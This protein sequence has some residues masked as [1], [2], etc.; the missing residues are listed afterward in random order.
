MKRFG[1]LFFVLLFAL[2]CVKDPPKVPVKG[3]GDINLPTSD[4]LWDRLKVLTKEPDAAKNGVCNAIAYLNDKQGRKLL[5]DCLEPII[6]EPKENVELRRNAIDL[7]IL[8]N[9]TDSIPSLKN[10]TSDTRAEIRSKAGEALLR[11]ADPSGAEALLSYKGGYNSDH[12]G[13]YWLIQH[14]DI[15]PKD[16]AINGASSPDNIARKNAAI[17]LGLVGGDAA[18]ALVSDLAIDPDKD[19]QAYARK[20]NYKLSD[21][22]LLLDELKKDLKSKNKT[23][24]FIAVEMF[25]YYG[26]ALGEADVL[27]A[28]GLALN[29]TDAIVQTKAIESLTLLGGAASNALLVARLSTADNTMA[30]RLLGALIELKDPSKIDEVLAYAEKAE[31]NS[32]GVDLANCFIAYKDKRALGFSQKLLAS[33]TPYLRRAGAKMLATLGAE[34]AIWKPLL[35]DKDPEIKGLAMIAS[36]KSGAKPASFAESLQD[37][38]LL[39]NTYA[40][41]ASLIAKSQ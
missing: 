6:S 41:V 27:T 22:Q 34:E 14:V 24:R 20:V 17:L 37:T 4:P 26:K 23:T 28:L 1:Y 31:L 21:P 7:L 33:N 16:F 29:D 5:A 10:A 30:G 38:D 3:N 19:I 40:H 32:R 35:D 11:M 8:T 12:G 39:L 13:V 15:L 18:L 2:A 25:G 36:A 9:T